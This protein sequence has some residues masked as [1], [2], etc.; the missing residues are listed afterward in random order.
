MKIL[1][2]IIGYSFIFIVSS[3]I[4]INSFLA[5]FVFI[6]QFVFL[7]FFGWTAILFLETPNIEW[8]IGL[9]LFSFLLF[10]SLFIT[11]HLL[12][13]KWHHKWNLPEWK[14]RWTVSVSLLILFSL[15]AGISMTGIA[16]QLYWVCT[17]DPQP[18]KPTWF[19]EPQRRTQSKNNLKQI[20]LA[21]HN[22]HDV[23]LSFPSYGFNPAKHPYPSSWET[24]MLPFMEQAN[25]YNTIDFTVP[26]DHQ[27]NKMY[28]ETIVRDYTNPAIPK[29]NDEKDN[30]A[31]SH[32]SS[33]ALLFARSEKINIRNIDD[34]LSNTIMGG[35]ISDNL[36]AWGKPGNW[37]D[38]RIGLNN[39]KKGFR[40]PF[41]GVTIFLLADGTVRYLSHDID[42]EVLN[43]LSTPDGGEENHDIP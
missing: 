8:N 23:Y 26:W 41:K 3:F 25:L 10:T 22:F 35:E 34:G 37:R 30:Y 38:P 20:G 21:S 43:A 17:I 32:Y 19:R 11:L 40:G 15:G 42:P 14:M 4:L 5:E 39:S 28:F 9:I 36:P 33:N 29:T 1:L 31:L 24:K 6:I 27:K 7:L 18:L 16:H 13:K 2:R 12:A